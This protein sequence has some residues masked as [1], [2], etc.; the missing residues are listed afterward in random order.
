MATQNTFA[1]KVTYHT[2]RLKSRS[3]KF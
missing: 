2:W 3:V 1:P